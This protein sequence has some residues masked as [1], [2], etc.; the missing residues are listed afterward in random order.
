[1]RFQPVSHR[2]SLSLFAAP[3]TGAPSPPP[4]PRSVDTATQQEVA[5]KV[6]DLEDM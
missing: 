3:P 6:V 4:C 5:I 2:T 1:M